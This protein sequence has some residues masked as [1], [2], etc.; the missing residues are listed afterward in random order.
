MRD[1][2]MT[3]PMYTVFR[4]EALVLMHEHVLKDEHWYL[5]PMDGAVVADA[6]VR[7]EALRRGIE[8]GYSPEGLVMVPL[9][10]EE[11]PEKADFIDAAIAYLALGGMV[12]KLPD[13]I[14]CELVGKDGSCQWCLY[15]VI[16][17][18]PDHGLTE[19]APPPLVLDDLS[20]TN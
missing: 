8:L 17:F 14:D 4:G 11:A 20:D 6:A 10:G 13:T 5:N 15:A 3:A 19:P 18:K 16:C 12:V 1:H 2:F 9:V 7:L